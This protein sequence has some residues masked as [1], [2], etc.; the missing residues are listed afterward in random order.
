[1]EGKSSEKFRNSSPG[2]ASLNDSST[3]QTDKQK[4]F[5]EVQKGRDYSTFLIQSTFFFFFTLARWIFDDPDF[6]S[7]YSAWLNLRETFQEN[8]SLE[9]FR[10]KLKSLL[11]C[12]ILGS[13]EILFIL[14]VLLRIR[15]SFSSS[16]TSSREN[17]ARCWRFWTWK[18]KLLYEIINFIRAT[19]SGIDTLWRVT[20]VM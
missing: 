3:C 15:I 9:L 2:W 6:F 14:F 5:Q 13:L 7:C 16:E 8:S 10:G 12:A 4:T 19:N 1:M 20:A 17:L 18:G 11:C